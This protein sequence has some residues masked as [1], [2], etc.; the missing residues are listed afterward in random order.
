M[1]KQIFFDTD[2]GSDIDD[3]LAL[4]FLLAQKQHRLI[5][6]ST[7]Y[8]PTLTRAQVAK[9]L[10][11]SLQKSK[12]IIQGQ[13]QTLSRKPIWLTG[14]ESKNIN[15]KLKP[16]FF[17]IVDFLETV[18]QKIAIV[19]TGPLTNIANLETK[20]FLEKHCHH[21]FIMGGVLPGKNLPATEHNFFSDPIATDIVFKS[22]TPITL[23]PLN[24]TL[25]FPLRL[26]HLNELSAQKTSAGELIKFWLKN[27]ISTTKA[28]PKTSLF[29][30]QVFLHDP[31]A[32]AVACNFPCK[33]CKLPVK[34]SAKTGKIHI[35]S[36][37]KNINLVTEISLNTINN[38]FQIIKN[39]L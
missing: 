26:E 14:N 7:V 21:L 9:T 36:K 18:K 24:V 6:V 35:N 25:Q 22:K 8:G 30:N 23:I 5:G 37:G 28:F 34:V 33:T 13:N 3:A 19:A 39:S 20:G 15:T 16:D 4:I 11:H 1:I 2:I 38:I 17:S 32:A 31:I 10:L 12:P 27:W 29:F